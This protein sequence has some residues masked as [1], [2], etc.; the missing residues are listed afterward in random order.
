MPKYKNTTFIEIYVGAHFGIV[1]IVGSILQAKLDL[2]SWISNKD[3]LQRQFTV[4]SLKQSEVLVLATQDL[5]RMKQEFLEVYQKLFSDAYNRLRRSLTLKLK[6]MRLCA[7]REE[8]HMSSRSNAS[9][10]RLE[11]D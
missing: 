11:V 8:E 9:S 7:E 4:M 2:D 3:L 10:V 5:N 1:D 6:A